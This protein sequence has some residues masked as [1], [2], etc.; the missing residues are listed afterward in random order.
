MGEIEETVA[1][2]FMGFNIGST[3]ARR[4]NDGQIQRFYFESPLLRFF[5]DLGYEDAYED[6]MDQILDPRADASDVPYKCVIIHR[7]YDSSSESFGDSGPKPIEEFAKKLS[8][9]IDML[10]TKLCAKDDQGKFINGVSPEDF[11]VYLVA[12]SMGGLICRAFLQNPKLDPKN[13]ASFVDKF[14]TYATP[15]NGIDLRIVGNVP[16]WSVFG[17]ATNFNRDRIAGYLGLPEGTLEVSELRNFDA[18]RVFNLVGT[19]PSD[20]LVLSGIS[21]WAAGEASDGLVRITNATTFEIRGEGEGAERI[22][23]PRAFVYRSHSGHYGIVNSEEGFQNLLRFF[24]GNVRIDGILEITDLALPAKVQEALDEGKAIQASYQFEVAVAIRGHQWQMHRRNVRENSA[25]FRKFQD[26]FPKDS[27]SGK[28]SPD[29]SPHL[30]SLFLDTKQRVNKRRKSI[31]FAFD[32]NVMVPDYTIDRAL[33][34]DDHYEGG[35]MFFDRIIVEATPPPDGV[36]SEN[37]TDWKIRY[38]FQSQ[39]PNAADTPVEQL[40][41]L[42]DGGHAFSIPLPRYSQ[43]PNMEARLRFE[44]RLWNMEP[45]P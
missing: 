39:T 13:M 2:P 42:E 45:R 35:K 38:G 7:Y 12:H 22:E 8:E 9:L 30:F 1:D 11:R 25:I 31:A 16:G 24:F 36:A 23:S 3:K 27:A 28:S 19:N 4:L 18:N 21:R 10:R 44:T 32:L 14:F 20:Y 34:K 40:A 43:P 17:E 5:S 26:L 15:H 37:I 41:P 6:G 33:W 29:R